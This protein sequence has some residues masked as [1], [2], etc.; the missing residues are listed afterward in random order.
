MHCKELIIIKTKKL[1]LLIL[2]KLCF[3]DT[4]YECDSCTTGN[5]LFDPTFTC[6]N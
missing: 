6:D 3:G 5:Y 2:N 1:S 4:N